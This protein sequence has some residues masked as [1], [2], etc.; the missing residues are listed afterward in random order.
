[1]SDGDKS[2][3]PWELRQDALLSHIFSSCLKV[4]TACTDICRLLDVT[5]LHARRKTGR[6]SHV[7]IY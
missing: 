2:T 7:V 5:P 3:G 1:M 4:T 6:H